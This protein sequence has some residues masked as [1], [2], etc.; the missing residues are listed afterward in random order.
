MRPMR[1]AELKPLDMRSD[2]FFCTMEAYEQPMQAMS[3]I[4][5]SAR[6]EIATMDKAMHAIH[7]AAGGVA[8]KDSLKAEGRSEKDREGLLGFNTRHTPA[9]PHNTS[10]KI[11]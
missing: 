3:Q 9:Y 6:R 7:F 1:Q 4:R 2:R 10:R 11:V 5:G 8:P